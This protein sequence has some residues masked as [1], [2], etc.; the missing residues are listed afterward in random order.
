LLAQAS[1]TQAAGQPIPVT[2]NDNSSVTQD[3][4]LAPSA[5]SGG[6]SDDELCWESPEW[7][8]DS[9]TSQLTQV[10]HE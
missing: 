2:S 3:T 9:P 1:T 8:G 6:P 5:T 10:P 7:R 4:G